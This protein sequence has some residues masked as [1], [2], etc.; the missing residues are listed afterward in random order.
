[1]QHTNKFAFRSNQFYVLIRY[2]LHTNVSERYIDF[3]I[4]INNRMYINFKH[5]KF[6]NYL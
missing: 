1:M 4:D 6:I 2:E 5:Y 3:S